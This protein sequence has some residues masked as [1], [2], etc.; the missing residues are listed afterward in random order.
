MNIGHRAILMFIC[1]LPLLRA[2]DPKACADLLSYRLI[3]GIVTRAEY[4]SAGKGDELAGYCRITA[5]LTPS[6][7][8][9]IKMELWL[10]EGWNGK[11]EAN[12]NGGWTGSISS[13]ALRAG[14]KRGYAATMSDLGHEGSRAT[15]ALGHPEKLT[16]FGY[17]AAHEMTLAAKAL[18]TAYYNRRP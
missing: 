2:A 8:S 7:D 18:T 10:P 1:A 4:S 15:F 9:D 11:L 3:G 13:S 14:V 5:T 12:G 6:A 16:D 17:R